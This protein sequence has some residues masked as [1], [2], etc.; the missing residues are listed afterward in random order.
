[1]A[2]RPKHMVANPL[3]KIKYLSKLSAG[4]GAAVLSAYS[5]K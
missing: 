3:K 4:G 5:M 1:M 2:E